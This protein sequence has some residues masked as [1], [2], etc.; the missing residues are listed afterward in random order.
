MKKFVSNAF[1]TAMLF[2]GCCAF[3]TSCNSSV[4]PDKEVE[5][6]RNDIQLSASSRAA[7]DE[8]NAFYL[9]FT[10]DAIKT[11]DEN[12]NSS[13]S[14]VI[15]SPISASMMLGMLANGV[16][17]NLAA[18]ITG[19][20]GVSD[21]RALNSLAS[22]LMIELPNV[23]KKSKLSLSNSVW[24]TNKFMTNSSFSSTVSENFLATLR[25]IDFS[26]SS[27]LNIVNDWVSSTTGGVIDSYFDYS[28][29]NANTV[30]VLLNTLYFNGEWAD[31]YFNPQYTVSEPFHG[32]SG[33]SAVEM[34]HCSILRTQYGEN[35]RFK[36]CTLYF[37]N[38][39]FRLTL[40]LPIAEA[41]RK[42][43]MPEISV[44]ELEALT[45]S[46]QF[47]FITLSLPKF[48]LS[49]STDL[50]DVLVTAGLSEINKD[51]T[52]TMFDDPMNSSIK[53]RQGTSI[54]VDEEGAKVVTVSSGEILIGA[55]SAEYKLEFNRPFYFFLTETSTGA[56]LLSGRIADIGD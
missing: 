13:T 47:P 28:E 27:A 49:N 51:I 8:L 50:N 15:V 5:N 25:P 19:Y 55:P 45:T 48:K 18:E 42:T 22:N 53:L 24:H 1:S 43:D 36:A 39:A 38:A 6:I 31:T 44:E 52:C 33:E 16:E 46:D 32:F 12:P 29:I 14:N 26:Q 30:A 11:V 56:C 10:N 7:A 4:E 35:D 54:S 41:T 17:D 3:M 20:L 2:W 40:V 23:D 34:M 21:L 37:G 9:K